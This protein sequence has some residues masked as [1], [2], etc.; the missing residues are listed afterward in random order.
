MAGRIGSLTAFLRA[1]TREWSKGCEAAGRDVERLH[2]RTK[3]IFA[4]MSSRSTFGQAMRI[5]AGGGAIAAINMAAK[6]LENI[7]AKAVELRN[8]LNAGTISAGELAEKLARSAPVLG[9]LTNAFINI[10]ELIWGEQ[11]EIARINQEAERRNKIIDYTLN[12]HKQVK[13]SLEDEA[14]EI[15][16]INREIEKIGKNPFETRRIDLAQ[17][18]DDQ[19]RQRTTSKESEMADFNKEDA[20]FKEFVKDRDNMRTKLDELLAK[21]KD[22]TPIYFGGPGNS[23]M[24]AAR[25]EYNTLKDEYD[26]LHS[27]V[28]GATKRRAERLKE[29]N[30]KYDNLDAKDK[31][32]AAAEAAEIESD[33][34]TAKNKTLDATNDAL[35]KASRDLTL[36]RLREDGLAEKAAIQQITNDTAD[37]KAK[38]LKDA[39][40]K[41]KGMGLAEDSDYGKELLGQVAKENETLDALAESK[42]TDYI[43]DRHKSLTDSIADPFQKYQD[44]IEK[45]NNQVTQGIVSRSE[46]NTAIARLHKELE[47]S[48][49]VRESP[50]EK[51]R[52]EIAELQK[53]VEL[54]IIDPDRAKKAIEQLAE[55][56]MP[57][58][59]Y[60]AAEVRATRFE[61]RVQNQI[62]PT[63]MMDPVVKN[64]IVQVEVLRKIQRDT[65]KTARNS[66]G[67]ESNDVVY[68]IP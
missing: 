56:A 38:N 23:G 55:A 25:Q 27:M 50:I 68:T 67:S 43:R 14:A 41:L 62:L 54:K 37:A 17:R 15:R 47:E 28:E 58:A 18:T 21:S 65:E 53:G 44:D 59:D 1:D 7:T 10:R 60:R 22:A 31:E 64:G 30:D 52:R 46:A 11:A 16:R 19:Q 26:K 49:G 3:S 61:G 48:L 33:L 5:T 13:K 20:K 51:L 57:K 8:E 40:E 4:D 2:K 35:S 24:L 6:Q 66:S 29:I 9:P 45:W 12:S 36:Q 42:I 39:Q 63:A 32:K 34:L